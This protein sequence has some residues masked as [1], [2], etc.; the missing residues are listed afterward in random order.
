MKKGTEKA[1]H[2]TNLRKSCRTN[3]NDICLPFNLLVFFAA[4]AVT[5]AVT[6]ADKGSDSHRDSVIY[7]EC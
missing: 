3:N 7:T 2:L 6:I 1:P 4:V 5:K